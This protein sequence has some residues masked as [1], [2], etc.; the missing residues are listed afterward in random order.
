MSVRFDVDGFVKSHDRPLQLVSRI[1]AV[2]VNSQGVVLHGVTTRY[3][4]RWHDRYGTMAELGFSEGA[5]EPAT[6]QN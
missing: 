1:E 5:G 3:G 4:R 6:I 2:Q